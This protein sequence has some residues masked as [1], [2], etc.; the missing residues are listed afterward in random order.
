MWEFRKNR[1]KVR[2][3]IRSYVDLGNRSVDLILIRQ[4]AR[5]VSGLSTDVSVL[6]QL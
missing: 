6:A 3:R 5:N 2:V 1:V 4:R